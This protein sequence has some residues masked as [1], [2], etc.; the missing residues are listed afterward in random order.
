[1]SNDLSVACF[2]VKKS[3]WNNKALKVE[4]GERILWAML[5]DPVHPQ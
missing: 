3:T 5:L 1:M 2:G 4:A